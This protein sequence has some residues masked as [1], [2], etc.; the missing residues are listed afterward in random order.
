[1][2]NGFYRADYYSIFSKISWVGAVG[3]S[4]TRLGGELTY[5]FL[6]LVYDLRQNVGY[7]I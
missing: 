7:R 3:G 2:L 1:M 5:I 4:T 6:I